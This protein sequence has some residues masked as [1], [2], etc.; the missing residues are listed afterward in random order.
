MK[1]LT[2]RGLFGCKDEC[3][4]RAC[5]GSLEVYDLF[6]GAG[7]FSTGAMAAGCTVVFACDSNEEAINTHRR[8][9]PS[10]SHRVCE[11]PCDLPLPSDGR[12]FHLHGS[13]PCQRFSSINKNYDQWR[14]K[15][16]AMNLVEWY[17]RFALDSRATSWSMEQVAAP[18]VVSIVEK[19]RKEN[20]SR[21]AYA[22]IDF[23]SLGIPQHR[24]R[25]IAGSP[26]LIAKLLRETE[27]HA[28]RSIRSAIAKPRGTHVRASCS[29]KSKKKVNGK[30]IYTPASIN[31]FCYSIDG[32]SPTVL[33]Q[34][35]LVWVVPSGTSGWYNRLT[36]S[37]LAALQTFPPGYKLP[38]G[39]TEAYQQVGN[40]VP[41]RVAE[42][43]LQ[44]ES[45]DAPLSPSLRRSPGPIGE[46]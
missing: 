25:L 17:I 26:H 1:Q 19:V 22:I 42:L 8:N 41:P 36:P 28:P 23:Y 12:M 44:G 15:E 45:S 37:E 2:L 29:W 3:V 35:V 33:G 39:K 9:H 24:K 5:R 13:P 21:V 40:A 20:H 11:L 38:S 10:T 31:D 14:D 7:G 6:C 32:P 34:H 30:W 46:E 16:P 43:M 18:E 27:Q 4:T